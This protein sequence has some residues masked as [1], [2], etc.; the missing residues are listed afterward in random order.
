MVAVGV[1]GASAVVMWAI[2]RYVMR[3][4]KKKQKIGLRA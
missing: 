1:M 3:R 4:D 2:A